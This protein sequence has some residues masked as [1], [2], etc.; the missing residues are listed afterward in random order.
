MNILKET[1][2]KIL[3]LDDS[4]ILESFEVVSLVNEYRE[5]WKPK[6]VKTIL[7]AE[8]H[9]F[10]TEMETEIIHSVSLPD[11][12]SKYVRF[13]YNLSYGQMNTLL[14]SVNNNG[15]TPQYWKLFNEISGKDFRVINNRNIDDKLNQKIKLLEFLK[16]NG[17]WLLDCSIVGLYNNGEK[18][19]YK[20]MQKILKTSFSNFCV[21]VISKEMPDN[22][23]VIG[24]SVFDLIADELVHLNANVDWIHQP[25]AKISGEKRKDITK[26][27][28]QLI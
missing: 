9:V 5:Y 16:E 1:Y 23:L 13:V 12:P 22:I 17:V 19:S 27:K 24:K 28:L 25:N 26:I 4:L 20:T 14:Q 15:G 8:S 3:K 6:Q 2:L 18:P 21:P 7:L 10:T 11:Y